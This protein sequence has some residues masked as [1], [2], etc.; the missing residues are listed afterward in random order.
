[1]KILKI[2]LVLALVV[3]LLI[4][5]VVAFILYSVDAIAKQTVERGG[6]YALAVPTTL[7]S[8]DVGLFA[9]TFEMAGLTVANPQGFSA[10][11]FLALDSGGVSV[12]LDTLQSDLIELPNLN[13]TGID[14][15]LQR[16]GGKANYQTIID[17]LKR[18]ESGAGKPA[19]PSAPGAQKKFV[20]RRIEIRDVSVH[21]QLLPIGGSAT[22]ANVAIPEI[23]LTDVGSGGNPVSVAEL[24]SIV[25]KAVLSSAAQLGGDLI[26]ADIA[27][28]LTANLANLSSLSDL[29]VNVAAD[30]GA[31]VGDLQKSLQDE[32]Q[33][34]IDGAQ[35]EV[36]KAVED[37]TEKA[38]EGLK[39]LLPGQ[40]DDGG[41]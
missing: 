14:V 27:S 29:G 36:N 39:N 20:I 6:T 9:G 31:A 10:P 33:K 5:A 11:H 22:T 40:K 16:E 19:D 7:D 3:V 1:M 18:F 35:E 21:A 25:T 4:G 32:A 41:R 12:S 17:N 37:A 28:D 8:A 38:K 30:L 26:P 15:H 23:V 24:I 2:L 34:A 13:L